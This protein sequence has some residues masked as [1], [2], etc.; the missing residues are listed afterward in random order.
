MG[1]QSSSTGLSVAAVISEQASQL[2][3]QA[4]I[5]IV[6]DE[7]L[8]MDVLR[9]HLEMEGYRHFVTL[10]DSTVAIDAIK[11]EQPDILLLDLVMPEVS[12]F[13]ILT[14]IRKIPETK[15]I[16]VVVLTSS[17]DAQTKLQALQL[18]ATDFL[19]KP[20]DASELALRLRNTLTA[21][22]Y[23]QRLLNFDTLTELPNRLRFTSV[24]CGL[25]QS[26]R[27]KGEHFALVLININRFKAINDSLGPDRGDEVLRAFSQRLLVIFEQTRP[28]I[29]PIAHSIDDRHALVARFGGDCFA[30][31]LPTE[32]VDQENN[33]LTTYLD[34]FLQALETPFVIEKQ[35]I[36]L[37]VSIGVSMLCQHTPSTEIL[38]NDAETAMVHAK[39]RNVSCYSF[40]AEYMDA[41]AREL[42]NMEN[43]MRTAVENGELFL[44]YQP[45][46]D[47]ASNTV[48]GAE[49]LLRWAHPEFGLI[50]PVDFIPMAEDTGMIVS[51]GEWV[52]RESC[53]CAAS[54]RQSGH[55]HFKIAVNVSIRQLHEPD[56]LSIISSAL[57][58]SGLPA[59]ALIVEMTENMIMENA[60]ANIIKLQHLKDLGVK[61]SIDDFG[62][63]YS[64]LSYLQRFPLDQLKIDQSFI[65]EIK[66][67]NDRAPIVKAVLSL[68]HDLDLT[69]VAEG[70]ETQA[71]LAYIKALKCEEYQG[72]LYSQPL[73]ADEFLQLMGIGGRSK[74]GT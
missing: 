31:L 18:G 34:N 28:D 43:G 36:Y 49:A 60:E 23:Q 61:L 55:T 35:N 9:V 59:D 8:N 25:L 46:V 57:E 38:V 66:S 15:Q 71:Q 67:V 27:D 47:V 32:T 37:T 19:A 21:L 30:V 48:S 51:I 41:K 13:D 52:L 2:M 63:G 11:K 42:L 39:R 44:V 69:V 68:A 73:A 5:M 10:S 4:K 64:S 12:G 53:C 6:D 24:L 40:Y 14:A 29:S 74:T 45:K 72:F 16:P 1:S 26:A 22:A 50:S 20:V 62:T 3:D 7:P 70:I 56:F 65:R 54:V 58:H 33:G 17:S